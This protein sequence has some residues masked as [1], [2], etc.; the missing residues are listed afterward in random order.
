MGVVMSAVVICRS[1]FSGFQE[2][3]NLRS[4]N[5]RTNVLA[6]L[7]I[8]SY[9]TVIVP[10]TFAAVYGVASLCGRAKQTTPS[11]LDITVQNKAVN[12]LVSATIPSSLTSV[13]APEI[14]TPPA[15]PQL[16][17][18][19]VLKTY[20]PTFQPQA[21]QANLLEYSHSDDF[22][23]HADTARIYYNSRQLSESD[24]LQIIFQREPTNI[25]MGSNQ[26]N[27]DNLE[28]LFGY[29]NGVF[30]E[31]ETRKTDG[32]Y[33]REHPNTASVYS[34]TYLWNPPGGANK[35]E[36]ACLSIP[37]PALDS[38]KQPHYSYYM[39]AGRLD[40]NRYKFEMEFLFRTIEY[41][42]RDNKS[43]A[44]GG[45]GIRRLVLSRFGQG[46]F[47]GALSFSDQ[48]VAR[49]TYRQ[50]M[51][52]FL[53][54]MADVD[55]E[56]VMSEYSYPKNDVWHNKMIIGDIITTALEGDLIVNAWDP[57]SA[58][59]NGNDA[60][61]SFDGAMGRGTGILLTQTSWLNNRLKSRE[62]LVAVK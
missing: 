18:S 38:F 22:R 55:L 56:V 45:K 51:S 28:T 11:D 23:R 40:E 31:P 3:S 1:Y 9:S 25:A 47:L 61:H 62:S 37:A 46:A 41:A 53:E 60:D 6:V 44:F 54:R 4:N 13:Q 2:A 27:K 26:Y 59:G 42:V 57:H 35:I 21:N 19:E 43:H 17:L 7:K 34:E 5:C 16:E 32:S 14:I 10:L 48:E 12:L 58:P 33:F 24:A 8:I 50:Q 52:V 20:S 30:N 36:V 49:R 15:I 39:S 29:R